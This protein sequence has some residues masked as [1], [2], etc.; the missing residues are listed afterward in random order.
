MLIVVAATILSL[1][2]LQHGP[3]LFPT[4]FTWDQ[5]Y[6]VS[7]TAERSSHREVPPSNP[8]YLFHHSAPML[9]LLLLL[10]C[11]LVPPLLRSFIFRLAP[12]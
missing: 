11:P 10:V 8:L 1:V 12:S 2:D 3:R 5:A 9:E 6:R 7:W 4:L